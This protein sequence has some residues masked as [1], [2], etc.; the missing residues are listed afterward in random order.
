M[1]K[2]ANRAYKIYKWICRVYS[3]YSYHLG[4]YNWLFRVY[5]GDCTAPLWWDYDKTIIRIPVNQARFN[6]KY[7]VFF[8]VIQV[9]SEG[10]WKYLGL[11]FCGFLK[12]KN[13]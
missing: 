7:L 2:E 1:K 10:C 13:L 11:Y 5:K 12:C 6:G 9:T 8:F 4:Y 3:E